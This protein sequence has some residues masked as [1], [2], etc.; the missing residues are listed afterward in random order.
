MLAW[1]KAG[2]MA[3]KF[4]MYGVTALS[5]FGGIAAIKYK[6]DVSIISKV[7]A[8]EAAANLVIERADN[9]RKI[10]ELQARAVT[11]EAEASKYA[12][13]KGAIA[14]AQTSTAC[15]RSPAMRAALLGLRG[16]AGNH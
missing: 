14:H 5:L 8:K 3:A 10:A 6:Y 13:I 7:A 11:A 12:T 2:S 16:N 4:V 9:A 15:I 1:F